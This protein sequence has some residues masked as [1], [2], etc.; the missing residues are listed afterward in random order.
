MLKKIIEVNIS[1]YIECDKVCHY[2]RGCREFYFIVRAII[3]RTFV[4]KFV[5]LLW[6]KLYV[7]RL[8]LCFS[9]CLKFVNPVSKSATFS[10]IMF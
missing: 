7:L 2:R 10:F 1:L 9:S 3:L 5:S 4:Y 6:G 8:L